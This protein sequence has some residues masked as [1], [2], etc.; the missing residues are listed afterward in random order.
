MNVLIIED[1]ARGAKELVQLIV[2]ADAGMR[3]I[4]IL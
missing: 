2:A 4:A 3:V 1:E